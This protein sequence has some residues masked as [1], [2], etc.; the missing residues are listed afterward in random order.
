MDQQIN[1]DGDLIIAI[2]GKCS[3]ATAIS[4]CRSEVSEFLEQ[5]D[6]ESRTCFIYLNTELIAEM[7]ALG[8]K[9]AP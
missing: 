7:T 2:W 4:A 1:L 6:E 8:E 3:H 5:V 9:V